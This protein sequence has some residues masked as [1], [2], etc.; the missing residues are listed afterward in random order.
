M[1]FTIDQVR[2]V[3]RQLLAG[4]AYCHEKLILHRD[5]K[6]SNLLLNA[7]CDLKLAD[8]GLARNYVA[9]E[10]GYTNRGGWVGVH[11]YVRVRVRVCSMWCVVCVRLRMRVCARVC[12]RALCCASRV[13]APLSSWL[14]DGC[15]P[16]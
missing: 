9:E 14:L 4:L 5:I 12:M 3:M 10:R 7:A 8:F 11:A 6:G 13:G 2:H 16:P 15:L 1:Q